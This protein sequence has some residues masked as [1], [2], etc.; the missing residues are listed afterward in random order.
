MTSLSERGMNYSRVFP[1]YPKLIVDKGWLYGFWMIGREW[2]KEPSPIYGGYPGNYLAR[3][4]SLF[5]DADPAR[6][7]HVFKGATVVEPPE[8]SVDII[9]KWNPTHLCDA[10]KELPF[11]NGE[12][13]LVFADPPYSIED[14]K[15]YG[16]CMI[17]RKRVMANLHR[18]IAPGG[19]LVW[20]DQV[21]PMY[22][23]E[24][25]KQWGVIGV[26]AGTNCRARAISLFER[27]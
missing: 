3:V 8:R 6:T 7:L 25:W 14:A 2:K 19:H 15:H 18:V 1:E 24:N 16:P 12:F 21:R 4:R 23:K 13:T 17:N 9:P 27:L 5:P 22:R 20:L 10:E 26:L 11:E